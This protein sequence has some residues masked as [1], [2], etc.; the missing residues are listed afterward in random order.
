VTTW[1]DSGHG[2][3]WFGG[4]SVA[5]DCD[6]RTADAATLLATFPRRDLDALVDLARTRAAEPLDP[7]RLLE[8]PAETR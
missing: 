1:L 8:A 3:R 7:A 2:Q 4:Y 5:D 6:Q